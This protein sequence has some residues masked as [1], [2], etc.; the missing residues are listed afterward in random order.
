MKC[1]LHDGVGDMHAW[2][3]Q[4]I[5]ANLGVGGHTLV[6]PLPIITFSVNTDG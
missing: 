5:K 2:A 3:P 1:A 4:K 6:D